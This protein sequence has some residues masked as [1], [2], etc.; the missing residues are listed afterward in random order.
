M[1]IETIG[2]RRMP[3]KNPGAQQPSERHSPCFSSSDP[4]GAPGP[5]MQLRVVLEILIHETQAPRKGVPGERAARGG[6][7][8]AAHRGISQA[9]RQISGRSSGNFPT[10]MQLDS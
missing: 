10:G 5:G 2:P 3:E 6:R 9:E 8:E 1:R 7:G 4:P